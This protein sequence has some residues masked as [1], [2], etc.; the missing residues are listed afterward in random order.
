MHAQAHTKH[1]HT[2][3]HKYG[4]HLR[5]NDSERSVGQAS[6]T[7]RR[8]SWKRFSFSNWWQSAIIYRA[9]NNAQNARFVSL[10]GYR[11]EWNGIH[12]SQIKYCVIRSNW[13][14]V[15]ISLAFDLFTLI[16]S[17]IGGLCGFARGTFL[18]DAF[19]CRPHAVGI[20]LM[21][22][23]C[24]V[25]TSPLQLWGYS[26]ARRA[27]MLVVN[28][29]QSPFHSH[30]THRHSVPNQYS[31]RYRHDWGTGENCSGCDPRSVDTF[32]GLPILLNAK[33]THNS[34]SLKSKP[35]DSWAGAHSLSGL[36]SHYVPRNGGSDQHV[37]HCIAG[38]NWPAIDVA[39]QR[40]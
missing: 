26:Y 39:G 37:F 6:T 15:V 4:P 2:A 10:S 12:F 5:H 21:R 9:Q 28:I 1:M 13:W 7:L 8:H 40:S 3:R 38:K 31:S 14:I 25:R 20:V 30:M 11:F 24:L 18:C 19:L 23:K 35:L 17:R 16:N 22:A 32:Y 27:T 34:Q 33:T 29:A 36:Q